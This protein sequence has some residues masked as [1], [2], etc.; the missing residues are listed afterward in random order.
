MT[1]PADYRYTK[2]HEWVQIEGNR[3]RVG[4]TDHAQSQLGDIV[5]VELPAVGTTVTQGDN[6]GAV[7]S[8]KAVGDLLA[9]LSGTVVEVNDAL[10]TAPET[11][12]G[13]P[14]TDGWILTLEVSDPAQAEG[15]LDAAAYE[16]F[17]SES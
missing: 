1:Y 4:I 17:A 12:N 8:V 9:P 7:E 3:A 10:E 14:H 2:D 15:L 16:N 13:A 11:I 6:V 5:F